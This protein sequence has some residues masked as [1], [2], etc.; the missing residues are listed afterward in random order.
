MAKTTDEL[1]PRCFIGRLEA[2]K[3]SFLALY[4][5]QLLTVPNVTAYTCDICDYREYD[6]PLVT[7]VAELT[8]VTPST[9]FNPANSTIA[10]KFHT[11]Q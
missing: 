4:E 3:A 9:E 7:W 11:K 8:G 1:C 5:G 2:G 10:N 6:D